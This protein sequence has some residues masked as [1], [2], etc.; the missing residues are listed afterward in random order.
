MDEQLKKKLLAKD[1]WLRGVFMLVF[2]CVVY[3]VTWLIFLIAI[4]QFIWDFITNSPNTTLRDF[5]KNLNVYFH[6]V[7]DYLTFNTDERP[8]PFGPWPS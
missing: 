3:L 2:L 6:Q 5:T 4:F 7:I 8:F 1:K